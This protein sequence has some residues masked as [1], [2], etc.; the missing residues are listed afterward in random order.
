M[1]CDS[2]LSLKLVLY[3]MPN[4]KRLAGGGAERGELTAERERKPQPP[5][6]LSL[7][8]HTGLP[9]LLLVR[10]IHAWTWPRR[11]AGQGEGARCTRHLSVCTMVTAGRVQHPEP[12]HTPGR[13]LVVC[14]YLYFQPN[15]PFTITMC[16]MRCNMQT[17]SYRDT[18]TYGIYIHPSPSLAQN[19]VLALAY[20]DPLIPS[21]IQG[22]VLSSSAALFSPFISV[23]G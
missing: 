6:A 12:L 1:R 22:I 7:G 14:C 15:H 21:H 19:H 18:H 17:L 3:L 9:Q 20:Y 23:V 10:A 5:H 4:E 8:T 16:S 2:F 13:G 11:R